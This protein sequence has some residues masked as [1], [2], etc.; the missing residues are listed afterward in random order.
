MAGGGKHTWRSG[1]GSQKRDP[2]GPGDG[3][4]GNENPCDITLETILNSVVPLALRSVSRGN[5]LNLSVD[6]T[7]SPPRLTATHN[8]VLVGVIS[9]PKTIDIIACIGAD[10]EYIAVVLDRQASMCRVKVERVAK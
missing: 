9:H 1:N 8:G 2:R 6:N 5:R 10:N 3:G 7:K 4:P